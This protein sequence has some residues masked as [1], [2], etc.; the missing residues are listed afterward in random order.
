MAMH[1]YMTITG[2]QQGL[3]SAG[4]S[5]TESIGNKCQTAHRDEI[6]VL[7]FSHSL[8]SLGNTAPATHR[9]ILIT[10][11]ID[12]ATPLLAQA[13][14]TR[15]IVECKINFFRANANSEREH[16]F[17]ITLSDGLLVDHRIE[18][19][20]SILLNAQDPQEYLAIRYGF[21]AWDHLGANT[22][23]YASWGDRL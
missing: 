22:S 1:G 14:T 20:H 16:Y 10:K 11:Y 17:Q 18:M 15:E 9:P 5:T 2:K 4:C 19:P 21:I 13:L 8:A 7:S 6:M 23:G 3:I 12:K